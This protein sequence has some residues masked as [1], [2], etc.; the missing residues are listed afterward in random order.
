M[1]DMKLSETVQ[2]SVEDHFITPDLQAS[3]KNSKM[4]YAN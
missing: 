1:S 3:L 4:D 2:N